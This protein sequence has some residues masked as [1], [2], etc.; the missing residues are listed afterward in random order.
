M[1]KFLKAPQA[2]SDRARA[3]RA[4]EKYGLRSLTAGQSQKLA[5]MEMPDGIDW[6][7]FKG[8]ISTDWR[9]GAGLWG[10]S[11]VRVKPIPKPM[12]DRADFGGIN[13]RPDRL[14]DLMG[15][16]A[17]DYVE[18]DDDLYKLTTKGQNRLANRGVGVN[19]A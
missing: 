16:V 1:F 5:N 9:R 11:Q 8:A 18:G 19:E 3:R 17:D 2:A 10:A 4:H 15:L 13:L 14:L 12:R 6:S 7:V